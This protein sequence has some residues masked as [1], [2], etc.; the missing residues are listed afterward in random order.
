MHPIPKDKTWAKL[1]TAPE[2]DTFLT[3]K[4]LSV[5]FFRNQEKLRWVHLLRGFA[6]LEGWAEGVSCKEACQNEKCIHG[7]LRKIH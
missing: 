4:V 2:Q 5:L 7:R 3:S 1:S 6:G